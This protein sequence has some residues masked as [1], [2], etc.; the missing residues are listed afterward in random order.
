MGSKRLPE[1]YDAQAR[2]TDLEMIK[3]IGMMMPKPESP[4][5]PEQNIAL[6]PREQQPVAP[7]PAPEMVSQ[8]VQA[9]M[10]MAQP[11]MADAIQ[12]A[13]SQ[14]D[15]ISRERAA[16]EQAAQSRGSKFQRATQRPQAGMGVIGRLQER[17]RGRKFSPADRPSI[18]KYE[19]P[20][21]NNR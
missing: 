13:I 9:P 6:Q 15:Q 8:A 1:N 20:G 18:G 16:A 3:Q 10:A 17:P 2:N 19:H 11:A 21:W 14:V 4:D 5:A 7:Q 12:Q